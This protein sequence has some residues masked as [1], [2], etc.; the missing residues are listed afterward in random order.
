MGTFLSQDPGQTLV[1]TCEPYFASFPSTWKWQIC[2]DATMSPPGNPATLTRNG[3]NWSGW[4][5]IFFFRTWLGGLPGLQI[6]PQTEIFQ[7]VPV[8]SAYQSWE[9]K[10]SGSVWHVWDTFWIHKN[11]E[12]LKQNL[13]TK[14][15]RLLLLQVRLCK[16]NTTKSKYGASYLWS[17]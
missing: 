9:S 4:A 12:I 11:E 7:S 10:R 6:Q 2:P 16:S 13:P 8:P 14:R 1:L 15:Q 5:Q 3:L 17:M